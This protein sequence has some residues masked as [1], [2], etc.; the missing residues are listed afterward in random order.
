MQKITR[1]KK[2]GEV[3]KVVGPAEKNGYTYCLFPLNGVS[4]RGNRG[5]VRAVK[6]EKLQHSTEL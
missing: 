6:N 2:T 5:D 3:V 1:I 4:K